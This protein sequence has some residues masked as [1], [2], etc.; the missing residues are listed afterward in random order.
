MRKKQG[1]PVHASALQVAIVLVLVL[2]T[3]V[4]ST[5]AQRS[6]GN[7]RAQRGS[8]NALQS[9]NAYELA[10]VVAGPITITATAGDHGPTDYSNLIAAFTAINAGTHQGDIA[11]AIVG[12][13]TQGS[14]SA[15][16]NASGSGSAS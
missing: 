14:A 2:A 10:A 7:T 5:F 4:A 6:G 3:L 1:T 13:T 8:T 9:V 15:I 11:I 16:L 12:D